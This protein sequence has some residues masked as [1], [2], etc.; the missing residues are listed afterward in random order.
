MPKGLIHVYTGNGKGKTTA[1]FG[2][3]MRASGHG[4]KVLIL[5]FLKSRT[6]N[7]GEATSAKNLGIKVIKFKGQTTPLFDPSVNRSELKKNIKNSLLYSLK[8]IKSG[9]YDL[10]IMD[11]F[12]NL[13]R[14]HYADAVDIGEIIG[15]QTEGLELVFTGRGAPKELIDLADYVTEMHLI[16]HPAANGLMA[17]KGIEF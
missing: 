4:K 12:N 2:L 13:F 6:R 1:A 16:K 11:E 10:I 3:A 9:G 14:D 7:S 5:Q 15:A 8:Q 17:R